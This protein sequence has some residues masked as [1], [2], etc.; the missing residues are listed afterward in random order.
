[1]IRWWRSLVCVFKRHCS[2][3]DGDEFTAWVEA[4]GRESRV[5]REELRLKRNFMESEFTRK[6]PGDTS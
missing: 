6:P 1:M 5:N 3:F 4:E 2:L